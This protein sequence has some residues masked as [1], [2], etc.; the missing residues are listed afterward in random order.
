[1][2]VSPRERYIVAAAA[3]VLVLLA[4]DRLALAP[5]R[6]QR[7]EIDARK[8]ALVGELERTQGLMSRSSKVEPLWNAMRA[9]LQAGPAEAESQIQ[10][11]VLNWAQDAKLTLSL[12]KPERL[13]DK[14]RL[15]QIAFQLAG[16]GSMA[17]V[18]RFLWRLE[19]AP[20]PV[21]ITEIPQL[22]SRKEGTDDMSVQLRISTVYLPNRPRPA[23]AATS[24]PKGAEATK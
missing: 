19:T 4:L 5:L 18:S 24:S 1:M 12:V 23:A 7:A 21:K 16:T 15:P 10:H 22:A 14:T 6:E 8:K 3:V 9:S 17:A 2:V 13:A 11:A 20:I